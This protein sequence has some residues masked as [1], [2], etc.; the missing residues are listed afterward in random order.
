MEPKKTAT[1]LDDLGGALIDVTVRRPDGREVTVQL[2]ELSEGEVW[3]IRRATKWPKAPVVSVTK[4]SQI[5]DYQDEG[6]LTGVEDAN[7]R[8]VARL[9]LASLTVAVPGD[10]EDEQLA[11]LQ[12]KVGQYVYAQLIEAAQ[13]INVISAEEIARVAGMFRPAGHRGAPG[14]GSARADAEPVAL[15]ESGG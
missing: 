6:Y 5:Y 14:N 2:R 10:G 15:V 12:R 4:T 1:S 3:D 8:F 9:L 7:R 13:H 11:N